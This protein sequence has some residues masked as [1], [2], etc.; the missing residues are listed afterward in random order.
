M[1]DDKIVARF[2]AD[3]WSGEVGKRRRHE[4]GALLSRFCR[5]LVQEL[6]AGVGCLGRRFRMRRQVGNASVSA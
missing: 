1:G 3:D 6:D 2:V 4:P 5:E